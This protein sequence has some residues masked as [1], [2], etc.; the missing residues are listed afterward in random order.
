MS[1]RGTLGSRAEAEG[2][3]SGGYRRERTRSCGRRSAGVSSLKYWE[4][5]VRLKAEKIQGS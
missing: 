2:V 1:R 5:E 4:S 3:S